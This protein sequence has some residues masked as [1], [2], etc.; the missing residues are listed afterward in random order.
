MEGNPALAGPESGVLTLTL[1]RPERLNAMNNPL[2]EAMN[3]E[4]AR[5]RSDDKI[6]AVLLTGTGRAF[7]AGADLAGGSP[8]DFA[9]G[10]PD[11]G[12]HMDPIFNP[13]IPPMPDL[14]NPILA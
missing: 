4:L 3:R 1:N 14:P 10:A 11:L 9:A 6:R 8:V 13:I 5:A 7:C 12:A 2:I